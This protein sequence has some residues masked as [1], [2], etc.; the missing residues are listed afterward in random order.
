MHVEHQVGKLLVELSRSQDDE[1]GDGTTSVVVLAGA[2]LAQ[3]ESLIEKGV[4]PMK[5]SES[6]DLA[7]KVAVEHLASLAT[8][9]QWSAEDP[10]ALHTCAAI[11]LGSKIVNRDMKHLSTLCVDAVLAVADLERKDVNLDLVKVEC[12]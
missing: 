3:A 5:I 2:L 10:S 1:V 4:H 9:L 7:S 11:S 12:K 8:E 6:Y